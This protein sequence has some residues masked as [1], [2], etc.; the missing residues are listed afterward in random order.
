[1]SIRSS[2]LEILRFYDFAKKGTWL[3]IFQPNWQNHKI[4]ISPA[5]KIGSTPNFDMVIGPHGWLCGWSRMTKF[6]FKMA[7]G[8]HIGKCWKCHNSPTNVPISTKLGWSHPVMS[9]TCPPWYGYHGNSRRL[10]T[11][12]WT[13]SSYGRLE[14]E[15]VNQFWRNLV[16]NSKLGPQWQSRD[17]IFFLNSRWR[18]A[19]MLENIGNA[20]TCLSVDRFRRNLKLGWSHPIM[21]TTCSWCGCH[22]NMLTAVT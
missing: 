12:H 19:A 16:N 5:G 17:Q 11:A 1:M 21:S 9:L 14:A 10:A 13:F 3:G 18:T 6:Q 22:V 8:R 15:C 4:A 20:I 7:D 2:P